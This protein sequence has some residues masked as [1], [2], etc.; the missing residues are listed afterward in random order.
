MARTLTFTQHYPVGA[1]RLFD[2]VIDLDTLDAVTKPWVQ[3]HH[4]PSGP[5]QA[6]QVI[7]VALSLLGVLPA[8]PYTIRIV[9]C[10]RTARR[11]RSRESGMGVRG[12]SHRVEVA[13]GDGG[14]VLTDR[15]E[16]D[17][18]WATPLAAIFAWFTYRWRH[19]VRLRL[20]G[21]V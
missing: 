21:A 11:M 18:G 9:E 20:L 2:L 15:V 13:P 7:D 16:I 8:R 6:G 4:L 19:H 10:D 17:A 5:V 12:L 14:S 3:F 1:D